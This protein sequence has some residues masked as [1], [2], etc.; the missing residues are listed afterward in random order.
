MKR[1]GYKGA[2]D[3]SRL[4]DICFQ[5]DATTEVLED[6]MYEKLA[7]TYALDP[8][9]QAF[10]QKHNP[11]ALLNITERLLEAAKRGLWKEPDP[12]MLEDLK[13]LFLRMEAEV[14]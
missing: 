1:H 10:F 3:L 14:E 5:W 13:D 7:E 8:E 9:M 12:Q 2:G 6:W 4:V 11:Y